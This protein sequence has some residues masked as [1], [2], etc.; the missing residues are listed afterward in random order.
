MSYQR[1]PGV[2][3]AVSKVIEDGSTVTVQMIDGTA[4]YEELQAFLA[5]GGQIAPAP[6]PPPPSMADLEAAAVRADPNLIALRDASPDAVRAYIDSHLA[7]LA[8]AQGQ[9]NLRD[10]IKTLAVAVGIL[11]RRL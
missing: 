5:A 1:I 9:Q 11:A 3:T 6:E 10:D 8:T 4:L 7:N 2:N